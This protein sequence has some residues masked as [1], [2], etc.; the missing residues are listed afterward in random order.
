MTKVTRATVLN[1]L[2]DQ[3]SRWCKCDVSDVSALSWLCLINTKTI[4]W[5]TKRNRMM[6]QYK[7]L[8]CVFYS[9]YN[10]ILHSLS[11]VQ[12]FLQGQVAFKGFLKASADQDAKVQK[13]HLNIFYG[14]SH[15]QWG[16]RSDVW[17]WA[18]IQIC[19]SQTQR[20]RGQQR[21]FALLQWHRQ[22]SDIWQSETTVNLVGR[23]V[24]CSRQS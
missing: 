15:I 8:L 17:P 11:V 20:R 13:N 9:M 5:V 3:C 10:K 12:I 23:E 14:T 24:K 21:L 4:E 6:H 7:G 2:L 22:V 1:G 18:S 19:G 16:L